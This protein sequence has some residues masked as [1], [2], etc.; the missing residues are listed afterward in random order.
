MPTPK[1]LLLDPFQLALAA[2][3]ARA[4][5]AEA[6]EAD[7]RKENALLRRSLSLLVRSLED[8]DPELTE[9]T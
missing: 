6:A 7:L 1:A 3:R 4:E 5:R 8:R 9:R 2:Y